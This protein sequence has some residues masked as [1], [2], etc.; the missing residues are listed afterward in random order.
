MKMPDER[1]DVEFP[2][3]RKKVDGSLFLHSMTTIPKWVH[4]KLWKLSEL[5]F[6]SSINDTGNE[7]VIELNHNKK[8]TEFKGW[9]TR[10]DSTYDGRPTSSMRLT[11]ERRLKVRL[12]QL[13]VMSHMRDLELR[14][15]HSKPKPSDRKEIEEEIPFYEFLD[16]EWDESNRRFLFRAHYIQRPVFTK[17]FS[18]LQ[19]KHVLDI[20]EDEIAGVTEGRITKGDW[21]ERSEIKEEMATDNVIYT[22]V[23]TENREIYVGEAKNLANR[24]RSERHEIPGWSHYRVDRLPKDFDDKM[25]RKLEKMMIRNLASLVQNSVDIESLQIS[26]YVL[27]NK[28][29]DK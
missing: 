1:S 4:S 26:D 19:N 13:F 25:R 27:K 16:I 14:M 3:W 2:L 21:K 18:H 5:D 11:F 28:L 6:T 10:S 23:D 29:V 22:L 8:R 12:Q 9:V 15:R 17:L 24:F 20:I 7:V